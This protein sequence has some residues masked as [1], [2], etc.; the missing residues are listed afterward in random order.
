MDILLAGNGP[1]LW[2]GRLPA[3]MSNAATCGNHSGVSRTL[4]RGRPKSVRL[5]P[6][7]LFAFSP[8]SCSGSSR[9]PVRLHPGIAFG[10]ARN[11]QSSRR[12]KVFT[13]KCRL[14]PVHPAKSNRRLL[15]DAYVLMATEFAS[16]HLCFMVI[17]T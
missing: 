14:F 4:F 15:R 3:L 10:L 5:P 12:S 17:R 11:P 13:N 9:N 7:I 1:S 2:K 16:R 8:E 6:G